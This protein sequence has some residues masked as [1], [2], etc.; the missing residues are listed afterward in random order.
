MKTVKKIVS[1]IV[2]ACMLA[3]MLLIGGC[4]V[5]TRTAGTVDG[6]QIPA[7]MY[8]FFLHSAIYSLEQQYQYGELSNKPSESSSSV[9]SSSESSVESSEESSTESSEASSASSESSASSASSSSSASS[10]SSSSASSR[11]DIPAN[12]WDAIVENKPAKE[13]VIDKAYENCAWVITMEKKAVEYNIIL[14]DED[15]ASIKENYD[16]NGGKAALEENLNAMGVSLTTYDRIFKAGIIQ[17][18]LAE[19][20]FGLESEN[21]IDMEKLEKEYEGYRRV[22]HILFMTSDLKDK[23]GSDGK[24]TETV[25][26]QKEKI[27]ATYEEVLA[28]A[29]AGENFED[30]VKKYSDDS[31]DVE[32]GF[33]FTKDTMVKEF[34][35]AAWDL[36]VGEITSCESEYGWHIIKAYDKNEKEEYMTE[37]LA[38]T[39]NE[40]M[41]EKYTEV[42]DKWLEEANV[43]RSNAAVRRYKPSKIYKDNDVAANVSAQIAYYNSYYSALMSANASSASSASSTSSASSASSNSSSASK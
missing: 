30:L 15:K 21:P 41:S 14:S 5:R 8:I 25:A 24:V 35:K 19:L 10:A 42:E 31:M 12:L 16:S 38:E 28:K 4:G 18:K 6:E 13:Y 22:K 39:V 17:S 2:L 1:L 20:L 34:E 37:T 32:K 11:D 26:Q 9:V 27:K 29:K 40:Y 7:G 3:S 23:K 33:I 36:K 43:V